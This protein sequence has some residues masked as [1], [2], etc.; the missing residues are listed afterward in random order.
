MKGEG[1]AVTST[2]GGLPLLAAG[3][4]RAAAAH[5]VRM[6]GAAW[7]EAGGMHADHSTCFS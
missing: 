2:E 1:M 3:H 7:R 4:T 5:E 6:D